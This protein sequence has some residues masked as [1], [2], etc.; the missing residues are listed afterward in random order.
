MGHDKDASSTPVSL[1]FFVYEESLPLASKR[2]TNVPQL[3]RRRQTDEDSHDTEETVAVWLT[4]V[5]LL[6][7]RRE[8]KRVRGG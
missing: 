4:L 7:N 1:A 5:L 2:K 3:K 6:W 8:S